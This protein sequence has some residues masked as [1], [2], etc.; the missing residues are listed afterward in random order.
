MFSAVWRLSIVSI[1]F[2]SC[3]Y[4]TTCYVGIKRTN[5]PHLNSRSI[6]V[7]DV[8]FLHDKWFV[9]SVASS[10]ATIGIRLEK[11]VIGKS[12]SGPVCAMLISAALTNA[13]I[14]PPNSVHLQ[15]L[16]GF[17]VK[18]AT[19][20]LLFGADIRMII[21]E[22]G[23]LLAAFILGSV[24]TIVGSV[25]SYKLFLPALATIGSH[26]DVWKI[27]AALT[28]KNIG[29]G[30]NFMAVADA[31]QVT[32]QMISLG[33]AV[34][35]IVGLLYFPLISWLGT[36]YESNNT[37]IHDK[38]VIESPPNPG[39]IS[40]DTSLDSLTSMDTVESTSTALSV[41]LCIVALSEYLS[42]V[43]QY[44]S[45]SISTL[46]TVIIA[47]LFPKRMKQLIPS[48]DLLGKTMLLLF[49]GAIG[50]S[51]G[52]ITSLISNPN[53]G[54]LL[55]FVLSM[56][57]LHLV[58]VLGIGRIFSIPKIDL[59]LASNANIGNAATATALASA[60]GWTSRRIPAMLVGPVGNAIAG[61]IGLA[62]VATVVMILP[63]IC[64]SNF[65]KSHFPNPDI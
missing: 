25:L 54:M 36:P 48:G 18:L 62:M 17:V 38:V 52:T 56:Y 27:I 40:T 41:G 23:V 63:I 45:T 29:G 22:T 7:R 33:L 3:F 43:T 10:A 53:V 65:I 55:A 15:Q 46:I 57:T 64:F 26:S 16:S 2:V 11:T 9:W 51:A 31:L 20:F 12:L 61:T 34:D 13:N 50:N 6:V 60:K 30:L 39:N 24:G 44:P 47:T 19:P 32:P 14:I 42:S 37:N 49:F 8:N 4:P 5:R 1:I 21:K 58:I 35:N 28:S 59:L